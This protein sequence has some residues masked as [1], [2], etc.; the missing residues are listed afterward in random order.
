MKI[1]FITRGFPSGDNPM[2]GNYEAVQAKGI[3]K[4]GHEVYCISICRRSF[5]HFSE[6]HKIFNRIVDGVNV[7]EMTSLLPCFPKMPHSNRL[8]S[9]VCKHDYDF[10]FRFFC[11][12]H[13]RPD[14]IHCHCL[15]VLRYASF[16]CKKYDLPF[17]HTEHWSGVCGMTSDKNILKMGKAYH[18]VDRVVA[19][20]KNLA[21]NIYSKFNITAEVVPNMVDDSFF[22]PVQAH[23]LAGTFKFVT[24]G[25]LVYNKNFELLINSFADAHFAPTITLEI[26]GYGEEFELLQELIRQRRIGKQVKLLG[27]KTPEEV[28][29]ILASSDCFVLTSRVE[30]FGIVVIEAM[31]K[32]LPVISVPCG[33]PE[34]FVVPE[35]GVITSDSNPTTVTNALL[36]MVNENK[37]YSANYIKS[38]CFDNF[39][40]IAIARKIE[41]EYEIT[42]D[43]H[44]QKRRK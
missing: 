24:V 43:I 15:Y 3:A 16:I 29:E 7:Y 27:L 9:W 5:V 2:I 36:R 17:L 41:K 6:R 4:L 19:V 26:V 34:E 12:K 20:S 10:L 18:D 39:S 38:Y 1:L 23:K 13:G 22:L 28:S 44:R 30:T 42:I 11:K 8:D 21:N 37:K 33:G 31:A 14:V 40:Q 35:T 32:G 25:R